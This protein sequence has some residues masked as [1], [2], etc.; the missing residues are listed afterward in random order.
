MSELNNLFLIECYQRAIKIDKIDKHFIS[1]LK[2]EL[3]RRNINI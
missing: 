2:K 1:L 3:E